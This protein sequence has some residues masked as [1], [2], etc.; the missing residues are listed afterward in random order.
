MLTFGNALKL[1]RGGEWIS[2]DGGGGEEVPV[3]PTPV[4]VAYDCDNFTASATSLAWGAVPYEDGDL[5]VMAVMHRSALTTPSGWTLHA[6]VGPFSNDFPQYTSILSRRMTG[7]GTASGTVE[8]A[9]SGRMIV[10]V[11]NIRS[12]GTIVERPDLCDVTADKINA[13]SFTVT[14]KG[15]TENLVIWALSAPYWS[16]GSAVP[17]LPYANETRSPWESTPV[18]TTPVWAAPDDNNQPRLGVF[19]D[20]ME[21]GSRTFSNATATADDY[22]GIVAIE[23]ENP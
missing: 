14:G 18:M 3:A 20:Y 12:A 11:L 6:T 10:G 9:S 21:G 19:L 22:V 13:T 2:G 16:T 7:T 8:Q 17:A 15:T 23:I 4:C 5:L 1:R